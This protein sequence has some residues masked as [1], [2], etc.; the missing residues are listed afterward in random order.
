M[1]HDLP[2]SLVDA[3][4]KRL[5]E[6]NDY[7]VFFA[8]ALKKFGVNSPA[9]FKS[10]EE[11]KKFFDYVDANYKG[12]KEEEVEEG[13][14]K[15]SKQYL[16]LGDYSYDKKKK[17]EEDNS[18]KFDDFVA[19]KYKSSSLNKIKSDLKKLM[20]DEAEFP[21][22]QKS[23]KML[24]KVMDNIELANDDGVPYMTAKFQKDMKKS[25]FGDTMW[26]EEVASIII[27][28]DDTLASAIFGV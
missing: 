15:I 19:Y 8:K 26:R 22:S 4:R 12:E 23:G 11:K 17:V 7:E 16:K 3:A 13:K 20:K 14:A 5:E 1:I 28:H 10:D 9:D 6:S 18:K 25:Y 2:K 21:E 27:K 24:L